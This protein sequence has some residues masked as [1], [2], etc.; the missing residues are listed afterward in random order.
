MRREN[1]KRRRRRRRGEGEMR[2]P[3]D[4]RSRKLGNMIKSLEKPKDMACFQ[5][6]FWKHISMFLTGFLGRRSRKTLILCGVL[7]HFHFLSR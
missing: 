5:S 7:F 3:L 4:L 1:S 6:K 2:L